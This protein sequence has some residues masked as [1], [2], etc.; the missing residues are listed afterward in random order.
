[1]NPSYKQII[2]LI[3]TICFTV[4][5]FLQGFIIWD[6]FG[7]KSELA[8]SSLTISSSIFIMFI[9]FFLTFYDLLN[10]LRNDFILLKNEIAEEVF[11]SVP[12]YDKLNSY[13]GTEAILI[14]SKK[15]SFAKLALN[16]RFTPQEFG[17]LYSPETSVWNK[18]ICRHIKNGLQFREV[19]CYS[20]TDECHE[21]NK[22]LKL[23]KGI[24]GSYKASQ[25]DLN[26]SSCI[27]FIVLYFRDGTKE[28]WFGWILT[29][30]KELEKICFKSSNGNLIDMFEDWHASLFNDGKII[31]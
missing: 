11:S 20:G 30:G 26:I 29:K 14:L 24:K 21:M 4:V 8:K 31:T 10:S 5:S 7:I 15:L 3:V 16:T 19:S 18:S 9:G 2:I 17:R 25:I 22:S 12:N 28:V 23:I 13:T 6:Y 1:M 27:N